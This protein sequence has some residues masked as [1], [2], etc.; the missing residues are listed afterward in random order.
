M[1]DWGQ[2]SPVAVVRVDSSHLH[3]SIL[4]QTA[5]AAVVV[6]AVAVAVAA[7]DAADVGIAFAATSRCWL[8][9]A[10]VVA[11]GDGVEPV[12]QEDLVRGWGDSR[13]GDAI[14]KISVAWGDSCGIERRRRSC[15]TDRTG[16]HKRSF[17]VDAGTYIGY[18][19]TRVGR[20]GAVEV[21]GGMK[22]GQGVPLLVPRR[23]R[24]R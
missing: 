11:A 16:S 8:Q 23:G 24:S 17:L 15:G 12:G 13:K 14:E 21:L 3:A 9:L 1:A 7:A 18:P 19:K 22:G 5:A 6:V 10:V 4:W 20:R 2:D